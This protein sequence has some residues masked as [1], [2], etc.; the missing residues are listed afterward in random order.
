MSMFSELAFLMGD[1]EDDID[2]LSELRLECLYLGPTPCEED[3]VSVREGVD[4]IPAM[5]REVERYAAFLNR[6]FP[7]APADTEVVIKW[8]DHDFGRYAEA[9]VAYDPDD[10]DSTKYAFFVESNLPSTW[11]DKEVLD[12]RR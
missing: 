6:R 12:W 8:S 5:R 4:Y 10:E 7:H 11:D 9:V 1:D 3:C 2:Y